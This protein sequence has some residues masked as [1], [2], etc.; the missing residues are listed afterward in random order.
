[1]DLA[2]SVK[3]KTVSN[4]NRYLSAIGLTFGGE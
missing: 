3:F 2:S 4:F 1:M